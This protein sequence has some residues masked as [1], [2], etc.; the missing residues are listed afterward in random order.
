MTTERLCASNLATDFGTLDTVTA[1]AGENG[2]YGEYSG[3]SDEPVRLKNRI[4]RI[5]A[6]LRL[7]ANIGK[8]GAISGT[9]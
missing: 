7:N 1:N 6:L 4:N 8:C 3:K 9:E 2:G 5:A